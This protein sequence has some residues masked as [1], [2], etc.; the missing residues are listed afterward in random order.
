MNYLLVAYGFACM[1]GLKLRW[2]KIGF[3]RN[4]ATASRTAFKTKQLI[5]PRF[6]YH[7]QAS[8]VLL[9]LY[10]GRV[11]IGMDSNWGLTTRRRSTVSCRQ[12]SSRYAA[13]CLSFQPTTCFLILNYGQLTLA[14]FSIVTRLSITSSRYTTASV[15]RCTRRGIQIQIQKKKKKPTTCHTERFNSS[16]A[17]PQC[18]QAIRQP[19]HL[20]RQIHCN[21]RRN[22]KRVQ[23]THKRRSRNTSISSRNLRFLLLLTLS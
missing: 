9:V 15:P 4:F 6:L 2:R 5:H 7:S 8:R 18:P 3:W 23:D 12:L 16:I 17:L 10:Y 22:I 11:A 20:Y 19:T 13:E 1:K 21:I 14:H